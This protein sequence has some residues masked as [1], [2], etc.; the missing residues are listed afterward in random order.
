MPYR[1]VKVFPS[2]LEKITLELYA[3]LPR[4][5]SDSDISEATGLPRTWIC[6]FTKGRIKQVPVGRVEALYAF[7]N[8]KP[9]EL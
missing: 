8:G 4:N 1:P 9:L 5:I 6:Q 2:V 3:K 7:V